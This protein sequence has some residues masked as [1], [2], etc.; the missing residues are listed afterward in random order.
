MHDKTRTQPDTPVAVMFHFSKHSNPQNCKT[1]HTKAAEAHTGFFFIIVPTAAAE[2]A[3]VGTATKETHCRLL[4]LALQHAR[5]TF[6]SAR[7]G[8]SATNR[9]FSTQNDVWALCVCVCVCVCVCARACVRAL[10]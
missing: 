10:C 7:F 3:V 8:L 9:K 5:S 2:S 1:S 4:R 6:H